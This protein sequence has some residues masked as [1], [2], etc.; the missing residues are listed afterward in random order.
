[1][2][3]LKIILDAILSLFSAILFLLVFL[4]MLLTDCKSNNTNPYDISNDE[5]ECSVMDLE[6]KKA[7][8]GNIK[9]QP[10]NGVA[11]IPYII[12]EYKITSLGIQNASNF[13]N[14]DNEYINRIYLPSTMEQIRA[15]YL[16]PSHCVKLFF[17]NEAIKLE[18]LHKI[19]WG[20]ETEETI[21]YVPSEYY[22]EYIEI[23]KFYNI[24]KANVVYYFNLEENDYYYI[25]Y[26]E[27]NN[28][29]EFIPP[30]PE[31]D[32]YKFIGWYKEKECINEWDFNNDTVILDENCDEIKLY[33]KWINE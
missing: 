11:F 29:I 33:A 17:C 27:E 31:K 5:Y 9:Y 22:D 28:L 16:N 15:K 10:E 3:Y 20:G 30:V 4:F 24:S 18:N 2:G 21:I 23:N 13:S 25:D 6:Y 19:T 32:G 7:T 1:M 26:Y 8:I 14:F 12:G